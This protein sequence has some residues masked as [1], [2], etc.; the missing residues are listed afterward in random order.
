MSFSANSWK[1]VTR[2]FKMLEFFHC[3]RPVRWNERT[4]RLEVNPKPT[5]LLWIGGETSSFFIGV[6][7]P[8]TLII[9]H[10]YWKSLTVSTAQAIFC[11]MY[12]STTIHSLPIFLH[13]YF[14]SANDYVNGFNH[15][16][17]LE[18]FICGTQS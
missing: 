17:S 18:K 14:I 12:F 3:T 5:K 10:I 1:G 2:Y 4:S 16:V 15:I 13:T 6:F 8:F 11:I 9:D 7:Y